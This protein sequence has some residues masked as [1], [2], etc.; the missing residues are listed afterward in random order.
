MRSYRTIEVSRDCSA[1]IV[2]LNRPRKKNAISTEMMAEIQSAVAGAADDSAARAVILTGG[3]EFFSAGAD[4]NETIKIEGALGGMPYF[5]AWQRLN[6]TLENLT[7]PVLAAIEGFCITGGFELALACDIRVA[8][9]GSSFFITSARIG[10]V[11]GSGGT[12]RLPRLVGAAKAMEMLFSAEP[13]DAAEA[14]RIGLVNRVVPKGQA[15]AAAKEMTAVYENRAPLSLAFAKRAVQ[16]GL[17]M[18]LRSALE[19]ETFL[20]TTIYGS[21]DK[22]EGISAFLEKR[23]ARFTGK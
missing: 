1:L 5:S 16:R 17:R 19:L 13:M 4:L 2:K 8:G 12:Q 9:E 10:T 11:P 21:D 6:E 7:K 3:D 22:R 20:V 23:P 15:L 14:W 18:D